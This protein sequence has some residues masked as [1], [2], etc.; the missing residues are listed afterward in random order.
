VDEIYKADKKVGYTQEYQIVIIDE[1]TAVPGQD[2]DTKSDN[3]TE[4]LGK[5]MK[6]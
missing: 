5:A 6:K 2:K 4:Y 3:N 1:I